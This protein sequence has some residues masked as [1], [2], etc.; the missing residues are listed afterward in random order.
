MILIISGITSWLIANVG[1]NYDTMELG[2]LLPIF[3]P[4]V[5]TAISLVL[6]LLLDWI[7]PK[8]RFWLI[9]LLVLS[10]LFFSIDIRLDS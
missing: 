4:P 1:I 8:I 10:N 3:I 9:L 2:A 6:F 5:I 7:F